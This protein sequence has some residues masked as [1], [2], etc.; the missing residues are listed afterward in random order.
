MEISLKEILNNVISKGAGNVLF[1]GQKLRGPKAT[2]DFI[3]ECMIGVALELTDK[4]PIMFE[5]ERT[6]YLTHQKYYYE[7][8]NKG[9]YTES[10]GWDRSR[11]NKMDFSF[12]PT[13]FH[14]FQRILVPFLG[15]KKKGWCDE[16]SKIWKHIKKLIISGDKTK[17]TH[18][19]SSIRNRILKESQKSI[20]R[21]YG[22][23]TDNSPSSQSPIIQSSSIQ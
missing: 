23:G 8:G 21:S 5:N 6:K 3:Y 2:A 7:Y 22:N 13:F 16:N 11:N 19:Q 12:D 20:I 1:G 15:G 10:Y 4:L 14:Y 9:K 18:L 17:I